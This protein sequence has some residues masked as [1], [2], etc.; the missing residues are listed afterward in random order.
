[1]NV[2]HTDRDA[3]RE[4]DEYHREEE[5]FALTQ[6]FTIFILTNVHKKLDRF[7]IIHLEKSFV[8]AS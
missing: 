6:N 2:E 7:T 1:M 3:N 4:R 5:V 8:P